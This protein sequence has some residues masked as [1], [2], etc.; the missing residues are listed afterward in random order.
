VS[1]ALGVLVAAGE[2]GGIPNTN[3]LPE[4]ALG[5]I[6]VEA[7]SRVLKKGS[8]GA[9]LPDGVSE[10]TRERPSFSLDLVVGG[11]GERQK[12]VHEGTEVGVAQE[13]DLGGRW[14]SSAKRLVEVVDLSDA[15]ERGASDIAL[16][17]GRLPVLAPGVGPTPDLDARA[18]VVLEV[19]LTPFI[20][21]PEQEVVAAGGTVNVAVKALE[22]AVDGGTGV[23][24][25]VVEQDVVLVGDADEVVS[26][27]TGLRFFWFG[28]S[29]GPG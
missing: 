12:L 28:S 5:G 15:K 14:A 2:E 24:G 6:V 21:R 8:E 18:S 4:L 29:N 26:L 10:G 22:E 1:G 16:R 3:D 9:G 20:L 7:E 27:A 11:F 25:N 19:V 13:L 17:H 23:P